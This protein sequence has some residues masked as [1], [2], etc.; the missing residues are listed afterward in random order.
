[1]LLVLG[2]DENFRYIGQN[3]VDISAEIS[4]IY[5]ISVPINTILEFDNRLKEKSPKN[6]EN[7][8]YIGPKPIFRH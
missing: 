1:M 5:R 3:I 4:L 6:Q 8:Q 7:R 2:K